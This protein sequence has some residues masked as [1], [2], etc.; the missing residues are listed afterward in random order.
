VLSPV[1]A[2]TVF[3]D[4]TGHVSLNVDDP[5]DVPAAIQAVGK[6]LSELTHSLP[7]HFRLFLQTNVI[8]RALGSP[9]QFGSVE[10]LTQALAA[11]EQPNGRELIQAV[12]ERW[13]TLEAASTPV[14]TS[15]P[16]HTI[17]TPPTSIVPDTIPTPPTP[18]PKPVAPVRSR[19]HPFAVAT[20]LVVTAI[21]LI[22]IT[23][24]LLI[25]GFQ[26]ST[27]V[28][29][30]ARPVAP[31]IGVTVPEPTPELLEGANLAVRQDSAVPLP[32]VAP[33]ERL[34]LS[35]PLPPVARV[36]RPA[37]PA[38]PPPVVR[39]ERPAVSNPPTPGTAQPR[40]ATAP[41][42]AGVAE[43]DALSVSPTTDAVVRSKNSVAI[44]NNS[45]VI[46]P[47]NDP[48]ARV[49]PVSRPFRRPVVPTP[50]TYGKNDADVTPPIPVHPQLLGGLKPSSPGV[51]LDALTIA[52]VVN[53]DGTADSVK[54]LNEP[55]SMSEVVLLTGALSVVKSWLFIPATKDGAPVR[56]QLILPLRSVT[57]SEP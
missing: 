3:I 19:Y 50:T 25:T 33:A 1:T 44:A 51:R 10:E 23:V 49:R 52:V 43:V 36:G 31:A 56:Y 17:P 35:A 7:A 57:R 22:G 39:V 16:P 45:A 11:Y 15:I 53:A 24:W 4:A 14:A 48:P 41:P 38:P 37:L 26:R 29:L 32:S 6:L 12:Y 20:A 5:R 13:E 8:V 21:A 27:V 42:L 18:D 9:P 34:A 30:Q 46:P 28:L 55:Q 54:G 40:S 2:S 47:G